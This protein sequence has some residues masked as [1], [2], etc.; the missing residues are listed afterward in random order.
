HLAIT[1]C[2]LTK[3]TVEISAPNLLTISY[4]GE[5]AADFL[6]SSFPSLVEADV[7]FD[8]YELDE[9][10]YLDEVFVKIFE[11]LSSAKLLKI[12]ADLFL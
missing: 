11:K 5:P 10:D 2:E 9:D 3:C 6:L 1:S 12:C 7:D 8:I 4:K